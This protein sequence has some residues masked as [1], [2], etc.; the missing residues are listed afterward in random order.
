MFYG[1]LGN[2]AI[3]VPCGVLFLIGYLR[4]WAVPLWAAVLVGIAVRVTVALL[5]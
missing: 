1:L 3:L 2:L 5:S 4:R